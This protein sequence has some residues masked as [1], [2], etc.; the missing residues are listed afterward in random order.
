MP[1]VE[2][3]AVVLP[4]RLR[5]HPDH[6]GDVRLGDTIAGEGLDLAAL[7]VGWLVGGAA[8]V[9]APGCPSARFAHNRSCRRGIS[10]RRG[11]ARYSHPA[12]R[13]G[14]RYHACTRRVCCPK[15]RSG[16]RS[17]SL[18]YRNGHKAHPRTGHSRTSLLCPP[19][20]SRHLVRI[21]VRIAALV[22][23]GRA[24]AC[25]RKGGGLPQSASGLWAW[26]SCRASQGSCGAGRAGLVRL[27]VL[28]Q[29]RPATRSKARRSR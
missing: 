20:Q 26:A 9:R 14:D 5:V 25:C 29:R 16:L 13:R 6:P 7:G 21:A 23:I 27:R 18:P 11:S 8:H 19:E 3:I 2:L 28:V 1:E 24:R 4:K 17:G 10:A 22:V 15:P 12:A